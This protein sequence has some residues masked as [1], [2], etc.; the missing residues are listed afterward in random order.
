MKLSEAKELLEMYMRGEDVWVVCCDDT[1][2]WTKENELLIGESYKVVKIRSTGKELDQEENLDPAV[3]V[4]TASYY[5]S[6]LDFE[7][8]H[9][10]TNRMNLKKMQG[11]HH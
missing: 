7:I 4:E 10:K 8:D 5:C 3:L 11:R 2:I 6:Y 9:E 1:C